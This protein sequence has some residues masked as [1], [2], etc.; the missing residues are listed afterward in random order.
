ML[1]IEHEDY[2]VV[3]EKNYWPRGGHATSEM[4]RCRNDMPILSSRADVVSWNGTQNF[5]TSNLWNSIRNK[6]QSPLEWDF[7]ISI[8]EH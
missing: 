6:G 7:S 2:V 4:N 3:L 1:R 8:F 5:K